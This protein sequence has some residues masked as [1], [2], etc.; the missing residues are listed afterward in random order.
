MLVWDKDNFSP[1]TNLMCTEFELQIDG[2]LKCSTLA[3]ATAMTNSDKEAL[4]PRFIR[5]TIS[6]NTR[7]V[8]SAWFAV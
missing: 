2:I 4:S 6:V 3:S 1:I 7:D 5:S 8:S